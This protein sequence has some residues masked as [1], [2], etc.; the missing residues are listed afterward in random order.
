[1]TTNERETKSEKGQSVCVCVCERERERERERELN[2]AVI[3]EISKRDKSR[4]EQK[5]KKKTIYEV[6]LCV[7]F[8]LTLFDFHVN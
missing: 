4:N 7:F 3:S 6:F 5:E 2:E 8:S 1:L